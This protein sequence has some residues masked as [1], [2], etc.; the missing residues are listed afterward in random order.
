MV[1]SACPAP[2]PLQ[3]PSQRALQD[4]SLDQRDGG[5]AQQ[6]IPVGVRPSGSSG[7][8]SSTALLILRNSRSSLLYQAL[9]YFCSRSVKM[10][11][12]VRFVLVNLFHFRLFL[13][14]LNVYGSF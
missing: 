14:L 8:A 4:L 12:K 5:Q 13:L 6:V 11:L 3:A 2:H 1:L 10:V 9:L 7:Q